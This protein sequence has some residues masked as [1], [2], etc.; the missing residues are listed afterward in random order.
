MDDLKDLKKTKSSFFSNM[1]NHMKV[2]GL[3]KW[4]L[5]C[6]WKLFMN[7]CEFAK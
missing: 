3:E 4:L 1:Q 7:G 5:F 6:C 2:K